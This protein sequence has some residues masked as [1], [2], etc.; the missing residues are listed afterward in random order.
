MK[1]HFLNF[2]Q[3]LNCIKN[4]S[5]VSDELYLDIPCTIPDDDLRDILALSYRYK[6]NMKQ[7]SIFLNNTNKN[8]FF[9][10][11]KGYWHRKVFG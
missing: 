2:L 8:W 9:D 7:L 3:K 11:T 5:G 6:I 1:I 4:I 10:N